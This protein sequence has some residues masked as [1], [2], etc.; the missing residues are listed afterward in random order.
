MKSPHAFKQKLQSYCK[1]KGLVFNP[2]EL[3]TSKDGRIIQKAYINTPD[4]QK[5]TTIEHIYLQTTETKIEVHKTQNTEVQPLSLANIE[6][7]IPF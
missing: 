2:K 4:G 1:L 5:A 7:D 3:Q 6:N